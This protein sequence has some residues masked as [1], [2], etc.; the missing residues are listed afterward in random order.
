MYVEAYSLAFV[1]NHTKVKGKSN[2]HHSTKEQA[3]NYLSFHAG[4]Q[5]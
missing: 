2:I 4:T 5:K 1:K 3:S